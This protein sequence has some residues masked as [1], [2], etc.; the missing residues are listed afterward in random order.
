MRALAYIL[1]SVSLLWTVQGFAQDGG[2]AL[3]EAPAAKPPAAG[4]PEPIELDAYDAV[5]EGNQLLRSGAPADALRHYKHAESLKPNAREIAFA[6]GLGQYQLG[7]YGAAREA[8]QQAWLGEQDSLADDALYSEGAAYHAEALGTM[9]EPEVALE[10]LENAMQR[11]QSVLANQPEHE[12]ARDANYKAGATWRQIKQQMQEQEQE[13]QQDQDQD[14]DNQEENDENQDE[15][16][17][18]QQKN[19]DEQDQ[20]DSQQQDSDQDQKSEDKKDQESEQD[21]KSEESDQQ[22]DEKQ[23]EK[24]QQQQQEVSREQAERKLREMM[25]AQ[26]QR[27]KDRKKQQVVVPAPAA[28]KD[29]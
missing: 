26:R 22:E 23:A 20:Q 1:A 13:Q 15:Q 12:S 18:D 2:T 9:S 8:F 14:K 29:W 16:E 24:Q 19:E 6:E 3:P 10:R 4:S 27:Q 5:R 25:Q 7:E 28:K 21:Q 17:Q 11:Y